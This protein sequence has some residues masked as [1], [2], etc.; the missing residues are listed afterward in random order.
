VFLSIWILKISDKNECL[1]LE[2]K[3]V[4]TESKSL[5]LTVDD[6]KTNKEYS[7]PYLVSSLLILPKYLVHLL[8]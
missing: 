3:I 1:S 8:L 6:I 2:I 5:D 4:D 7:I